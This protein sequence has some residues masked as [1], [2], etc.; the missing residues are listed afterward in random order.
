MSLS[1]LGARAMRPNDRA[2]VRTGGNAVKQTA[3]ASPITLVDGAATM[4]RR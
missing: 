4:S 3:M 1:D 2:I